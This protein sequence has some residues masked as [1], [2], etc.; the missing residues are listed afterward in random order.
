M[1]PFLLLGTNFVYLQTAGGGVWACK[2]Q[3]KAS[4]LG[5]VRSLMQG[6]GTTLNC[7]PAKACFL[8][9]SLQLTHRI[10]L[11]RK[12]GSIDKHMGPTA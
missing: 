2:H 9:N 3:R 4:W 10:A 12:D 1:F 8:P 5:S 6:F 11:Q 7:F